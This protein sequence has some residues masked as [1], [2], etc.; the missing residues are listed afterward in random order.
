MVR[1]WSRS[2]RRSRERGVNGAGVGP[3]RRIGCGSMCAIWSVSVGRLGCGSG[4]A[5]GDAASC[6]VWPRPGLRRSSS[7]MPRSC[8][9]GAP[10]PRAAPEFFGASSGLSGLI[11]R[12]S[13]ALG[14]LNNSESTQMLLSGATSSNEGTRCQMAL[15]LADP[16][17]TPDDSPG[18]LVGL[19]NDRSFAVRRAAARSTAHRVKTGDDALLVQNL[20]LHFLADAGRTIRLNTVHALRSDL[21][22]S[23][24]VRAFVSPLVAHP[25]AFLRRAAEVVLDPSSES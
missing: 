6:F 18:I 25:S 3:S 8:S 10:V 22:P 24:A 1:S 5:G 17:L 23:D 7:W 20:L 12:V 13:L 9:P 16:S 19:A 21:E 14:L 2:R 15:M 4:S 11:D